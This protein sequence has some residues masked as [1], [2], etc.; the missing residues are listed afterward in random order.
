VIP[1]TT[2]RPRCCC[3]QSTWCDQHRRVDESGVHWSVTKGDYVPVGEV[4]RGIGTGAG[5]LHGGGPG[6]VFIPKV[7]AQLQATCVSR[8]HAP[9]DNASSPVIAI[10]A[11]SLR[12]GAR[13][14]CTG[15]STSG[16]PCRRGYGA[17]ALVRR[18]S[19]PPL[20]CPGPGFFC[21]GPPCPPLPVVGHFD[22][23]GWPPGH[24]RRAW[25]RGMDRLARTAL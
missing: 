23:R 5:H 18:A 17:T 13:L 4:V 11:T 22:D 25:F 10:P 1:E 3:L 2:S 15:H 12:I 19:G 20:D 14:P 21:P 7:A 9:S 8:P 16:V 24:F 6:T